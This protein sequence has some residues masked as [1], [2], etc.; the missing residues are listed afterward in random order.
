MDSPFTNRILTTIDVREELS[1]APLIIAMRSD[2][3][4]APAA[5]FLLDLMK[6]AAGHPGSSDGPAQQ[7]IGGRDK[8]KV[9]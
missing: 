2:V 1:P 9:K 5:D 6:R 3:P 7:F 8:M 4:L